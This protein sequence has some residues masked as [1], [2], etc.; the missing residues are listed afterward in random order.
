MDEG[1]LNQLRV[2][3][4]SGSL[5]AKQIDRKRVIHR[6]VWILIRL[7]VGGKDSWTVNLN[8]LHLGVPF[9]GSFPFLFWRM[10]LSTVLDSVWR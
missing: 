4:S 1:K 8:G 7:A 10:M 2:L 9:F 6:L 5:A 3:R